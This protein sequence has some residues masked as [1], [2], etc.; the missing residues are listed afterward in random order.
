MQIVPFVEVRTTR[1]FR[2]ISDT[3]F[4][5]LGRGEINPVGVPRNSFERVEGFL[6][7]T[8]KVTK[9]SSQRTGHQYSLR[10]IYDGRNSARLVHLDRSAKVVVDGKYM[11]IAD[12]Y[13]MHSAS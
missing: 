1:G 10:E 2:V 11:C 6:H 9:L 12:F 4:G 8:V 5:Y 3:P 13:D 7:G